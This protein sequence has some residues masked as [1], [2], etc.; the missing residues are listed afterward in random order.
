VRDMTTCGS[1]GKYGYYGN[2]D[3]EMV[4]CVLLYEQLRQNRQKRDEIRDSEGLMHCRRCG[5]A[6][7]A[8]PKAKRGRPS[9]YCAE[10]QPFKRRERYKKWRR[11][12]KAAIN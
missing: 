5:V 2:L 11:K 6:L 7:V 12:T 1:I 3:V 4:R 9:Q 8:K 10:C